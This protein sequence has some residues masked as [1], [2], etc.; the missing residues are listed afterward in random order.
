MIS[1]LPGRL[2]K[3]IYDFNHWFSPETDSL[4]L[5]VSLHDYGVF[6]WFPPCSALAE[7]DKLAFDSSAIYNSELWQVS[8]TLWNSI[9]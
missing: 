4:K 7:S 9:S 1:C 8:Q 2:T 5:S 3:T 6:S